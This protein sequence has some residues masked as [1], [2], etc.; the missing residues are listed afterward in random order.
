[1][2]VAVAGV[3]AVAVAVVEAVAVATAAVAEAVAVAAAVV[4]GEGVAAVAGSAVPILVGPVR[5]VPA[6]TRDQVRQRHC[7]H[8]GLFL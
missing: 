7:N 3:V 8:R 6:P 5:N 2:A 1:M 4:G